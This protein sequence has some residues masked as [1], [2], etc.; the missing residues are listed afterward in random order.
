[1]SATSPLWALLVV[2]AAVGTAAA[3]GVFNAQ[4]YDRSRNVPI[5]GLRGLL[6]VFVFVHHSS[7]W[8][9]FLESSSWNLPPS[10]LYSHLGPSS[11]AI[12]F[13]ITAFLFIQKII[14]S[15]EGGVDWVRVYISRIARIIPLFA[16]T[17]V[18]SAIIVAYIS[19][20]RSLSGGVA[21]NIKS[22][23]E[24]FT[25]GIIGIHGPKTDVE[26]LLTSN[27]M[28]FVTWSLIYEWFFYFSLPV[29]AM[30][31]G[32]R[33]SIF[34]LLLGALGLYG[35]YRL[36]VDLLFQ[37]YF[38][39][40][41]VAVFLAKWSAYRRFSSTFLASCLIIFF[42]AILVYF[43]IDTWSGAWGPLLLCLVLS[44]VASGNSIFGILTIRPAIFLGD[45]SFSIYML[46]G[47]VLYIVIN[48]FFGAGR[49]RSMGPNEYWLVVVMI[50]PFL[51]GV[52]FVSYVLVERPSMRYGKKFGLVASD[53]LQSIRRRQPRQ[54][55]GE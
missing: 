16:L 36:N 45:I 55:E 33:S 23:I 10:S 2:L 50:T 9:F 52:C 39:A 18:L 49:F 30:V 17:G 15:R 31:F 43:D 53:W 25:F 37:K 22:I 1:M 42:A 19:D 24:W 20:G 54:T 11:V 35:L 28:A 21:A 47:I 6:A 5:D 12:F 3:F 14:D 44:T 8:F 4:G 34:P 13:M 27:I 51:V 38:F 29:I 48:I 41:A 40:G 32:V 46:H 7:V 26:G